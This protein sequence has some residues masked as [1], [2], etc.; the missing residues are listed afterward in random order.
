VPTR[1]AHPVP[2]RP[3][4]ARALEREARSGNVAIVERAFDIPAGQRL[5]P[6]FVPG[7][8]RMR[9]IHVDETRFEQKDDRS[10]AVPITTTDPSGRTTTWTATLGLVDGTWRI[11]LTEPGTR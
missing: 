6:G 4:S 8:A 2:L 11:A 1:I 9:S 7:L 5:D 3:A 10:A